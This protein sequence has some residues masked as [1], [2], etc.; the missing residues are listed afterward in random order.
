MLTNGRTASDRAVGAVAFRRS[1]DVPYP[2]QCEHQQNHRGRGGITPRPP[3][4]RTTSTRSARGGRRRR[5]ARRRFRSWLSRF[6]RQRLGGHLRWRSRS[7]RR[8]RGR[9]GGGLRHRARRRLDAKPL[10]EGS[11]GGVGFRL[12]LLSQ[13]GFV[14]PG[15]PERTRAVPGRIQ[16][17]HEAQRH[18]STIWIVRRQPARPL[19][20]RGVITLRLAPLGERFQRARVTLGE[21]RTLAVEPSLELAPVRQVEAIQQRTGERF[22]GALRARP[23]RAAARRSRRRS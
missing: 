3:R 19:L 16:R 11:D 18:A 7:G 14:D 2:R 4:S 9:H 21:P 23:R 12:E 10:G 6:L 17:A 22:D 8:A 15:V 1:R 20:R 5:H 13:H